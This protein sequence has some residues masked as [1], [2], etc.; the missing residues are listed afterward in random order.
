MN[1]KEFLDVLATKLNTTKS[2]ADKE[3]TAVLDCIAEVMKDS[4][5]LRFVG[6][7]TFKAKQTK[8]MKVRTPR[9]DMADVPAQRQVRFSV[10]K[11]F[12]DV[13]NSK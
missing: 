2:N 3:L 11:E 10:G 1:K 7:G 4:D 5:E 9:G 12:K 13:V 8:A 6:F